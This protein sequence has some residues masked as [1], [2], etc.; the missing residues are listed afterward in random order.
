MSYEE[1]IFSKLSQ[2]VGIGLSPEK[3]PNLESFRS[4]NF[5][6]ASL[7]PPRIKGIRE[8]MPIA[9]QL[10]TKSKEFSG[11]SLET[12]SCQPKTLNQGITIVG[13]AIF[14]TTRNRFEFAQ[15]WLNEKSDR[16]Y[17]YLALIWTINKK[18]KAIE[19][20]LMAMFPNNS[21]YHI[22][23]DPI[24]TNH[25]GKPWKLE[26]HYQPETNGLGMVLNHRGLIVDFFNQDKLPVLIQRVDFHQALRIAE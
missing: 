19:P 7:I 15:T 12:F 11:L 1:R 23:V 4:T 21:F 9:V 22:Y 17:N 18:E 8:E 6:V 14:G 24:G 5:L 3:T 13:G 20:R 16:V 25:E 10:R 2:V 26:N